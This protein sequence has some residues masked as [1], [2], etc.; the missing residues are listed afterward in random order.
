MLF[1]NRHTQNFSGSK[2]GQLTHLQ[3]VISH[4]LPICVKTMAN[5]IFDRCAQWINLLMRLKVAIC[6]VLRGAYREVRIA[7]CVSRGSLH[8]RFFSNIGSQCWFVVE[9][10]HGFKIPYRFKLAHT[11]KMLKSQIWWKLGEGVPVT[12]R[13]LNFPIMTDAYFWLWLL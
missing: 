7:R 10:R 9:M 4:Y 1:T 2:M 13:S 3:W 5:I 11:I 12:V 8:W 6:Y